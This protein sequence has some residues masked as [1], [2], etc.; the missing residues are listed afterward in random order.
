MAVS[1]YHRRLEMPMKE[2]EVAR[3]LA[4]EATQRKKEKKKS[5]N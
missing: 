5:E 2:R 4:D 3:R 1:S